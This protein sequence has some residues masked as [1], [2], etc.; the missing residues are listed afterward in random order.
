MSRKFG[1]WGLVA[2]AVVLAIALGVYWVGRSQ[3]PYALHGRA[4]DPPRPAADFGLTGDA[5]QTYSLSSFRGKVVLIYFGYTHCPDVCPTTVSEVGRA[6]E[7]LGDAAQQA[8]F[9]MITVDPQRDTAEKLAA[10]MGHFNPSFLGLTGAPEEIKAVADHYGVFFEYEDHGSEAGYL[11]S[12]TASLML[13]DAEGMWRTVYPFGT[14][15]EEIVPDIR[16][17]LDE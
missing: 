17:L 3:H 4:F 10:Y 1:L 12:H 11:V 9:I 2:L 5:G 16:H 15:L 14:P 6:F 13:V 8:Q 7:Q